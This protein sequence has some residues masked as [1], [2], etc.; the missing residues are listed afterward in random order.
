MSEAALAAE[1]HADWSVGELWVISSQTRALA[2]SA[3]LW[4][5]VD[6]ARRLLARPPAVDRDDLV[7]WS[8][9]TR[10]DL[11]RLLDGVL[12]EDVAEYRALIDELALDAGRCSLSY[13]GYP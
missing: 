4:I 5:G 12:P 10:E 7:T 13:P 8:N 6:D 2:G 3:Q 9:V 11:E 1:P